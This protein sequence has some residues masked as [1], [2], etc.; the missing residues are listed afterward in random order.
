MTAL[1]AAV[2]A[3][4]EDARRF[5]FLG[6]GPVDDQVSHAVAMA[7]VLEQNHV[8]PAD[9]LDLGSGGGLPGLVLAAEWP[10]QSATLL[11]GSAR[12]TAFLRQTVI[13]LD[14]A[15][16]VRVAEGQA[17]KLGRD[18]GLR[19]GFPLV[20]ARSFAAPAITAEVG[21]VFVARRR[22]AG[23]ERAERPTRSSAV[24]D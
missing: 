8:A 7:R 15:S 20:V 19:A 16:R 18:P 24:A 10:E 1:D 23:G 6:P 22:G 11:D 17:E 5:G 3:A 14:W 21:G 4:L 12:R 9:F 13:G 2:T